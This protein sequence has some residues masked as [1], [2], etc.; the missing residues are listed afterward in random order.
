MLVGLA[1]GRSARRPI[2]FW[3]GLMTIFAAL[4]VAIGVMVASDRDGVWFVVGAGV[5]GSLIASIIALWLDLVVKAS[6]GEGRDAARVER[7]VT[8]LALSVPLLEH[9]VRHGIRALKPKRDYETEEWVAILASARKQLFIVGH[10][11]DS[12]CRADVRPQFTATLRRLVLDGRPVRLIALPPDGQTTV[13]LGEQ[14][15]QDYGRRIR[16]T[17]SVLAGLHATLPSERREH[18]DVRVL[19]EDVPMPYMVA[20]NEHTLVTSPYPI[21]ARGSGTMLAMEVDTTTP[22]GVALLEDLGWLA[23]R[24][25]ER[26]DLESWAQNHG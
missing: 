26:V 5:L 8:T 22:F 11:L 21:A 7:A 13:R 23:E 16:Q 20:G 19:H 12:W 14:R 3:L 17:M 15:G 1:P 18:L 2:G 10:A 9:G 24:H 25:S 4:L 6:A